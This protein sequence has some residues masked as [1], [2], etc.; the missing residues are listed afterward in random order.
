M[1]EAVPNGRSAVASKAAQL[2]G[3]GSGTSAG[4]DQAASAMFQLDVTEVT[5][6]VD[7]TGRM[8][9]FA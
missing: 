4:K 9:T 5:V 1:L 2:A 6:H 7:Q 3:G 8:L